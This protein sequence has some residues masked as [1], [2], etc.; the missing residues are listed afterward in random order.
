VCVRLADAVGFCLFLLYLSVEFSLRNVS[1]SVPVDRSLFLSS[2]I[3]DL[4]LL[5]LIDGVIFGEFYL[6]AVIFLGLHR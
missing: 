1:G 5:D 3:S 2:C 6:N 4:N